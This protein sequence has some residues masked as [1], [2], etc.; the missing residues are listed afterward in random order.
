MTLAHHS[1]QGVTIRAQTRTWAETLAQPARKP[2]RFAGQISAKCLAGHHGSACVNR[3]CV[4][5]CHNR[6][7]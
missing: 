6:Q 3:H 2:S 7:S 4:C 1:T 5:G